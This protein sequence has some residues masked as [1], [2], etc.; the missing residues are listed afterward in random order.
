MLTSGET[1]LHIFPFLFLLSLVVSIAS[2]EPNKSI[3][4]LRRDKDLQNLETSIDNFN[5]ILDANIKKREVDCEMAVGYKP[6]CS[7]IMKELPI[8]WSFSDYIKI[9]IQ[10]KEENGYSKMDKELRLAYDKVEPIRD[11]CVRIINTKP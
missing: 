9:T 7:C 3:E 10:T 11:S 5:A 4:Q 6:F 1:K 2:A 8:A